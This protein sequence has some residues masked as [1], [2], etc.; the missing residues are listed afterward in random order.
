MVIF[1]T[2]YEQAM[3]L[4]GTDCSVSAQSGFIKVILNME[5]GGTLD[6]AFRNDRSDRWVLDK[7][8][9][10]LFLTDIVGV[11]MRVTS[12]HH[13]STWEFVFYF[14]GADESF[15]A[16]ISARREFHLDIKND[17]GDMTNNSPKTTPYVQSP[18][19]DPND[20]E[21]RRREYRKIAEWIDSNQPELKTIHIDSLA[22]WNRLTTFAAKMVSGVAAGSWE[23]Y[24]PDKSIDVAF[25]S[26]ELDVNAG[27]SETITITQDTLQA[28][29]TA[30]AIADYLTWEFGCSNVGSSCSFLLGVDDTF[31]E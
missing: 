2:K 22:K 25:Y 5:P 26:W 24:H 21:S 3:E 11:T 28:F 12:K 9:F 14:G 16:S 23:I 17:L 6:K 20:E 30:I 10:L 18:D 15:G 8:R 7:N 4:F 19:F 31:T 1:M 29:T 27:K 13:L